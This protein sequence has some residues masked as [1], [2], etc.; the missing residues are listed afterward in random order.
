[1]TT[2]VTKMWSKDAFD[3]TSETGVVKQA[4]IVEGYQITV[5]ADF[6]KTQVSQVAGVPLIADV[7]PD[8]TDIRVTG[9]NYQRLGPIYWLAI[10]TYEGEFPLIGERPRIRWTNAASNE[11]I[12]EDADGKPIVTACGEPIDGATKEVSDLVLNVDRSFRSLN[13][14]ATHQYLESVNSDQF[15]GFAA[16]TGRLRAFDA[17]QL[18]NDNNPYW[19][20]SARIQ[21]RF[22]YRTTPEKA[23]YARLR[24]EGYY[25]KDGE[26]I[27]RAVDNNKEP[28][29]RP[30]LLKENGEKETDSDNAYWKEF[31]R[32]TPLPYNA[33]GLLD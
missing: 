27:V 22:P 14:A 29:T 24:H 4:R 32:Y 13:L 28:V 33:L 16:G 20:V 21:F 1:M 7:W 12:D 15:A 9:R 19:S 10:V 18:Y 17:E 31:K 2:E 3:I 5:P 11:G 6:T 8:N 23:W 30:V 25:V 26:R